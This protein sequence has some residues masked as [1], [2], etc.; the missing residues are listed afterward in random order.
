VIDCVGSKLLTNLSNGE[1]I[2]NDICD[3]N[4]HSTVETASFDGLAETIA[5]RTAF[6]LNTIC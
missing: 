3:W 4:V 6:A 2:D 5:D 1:L